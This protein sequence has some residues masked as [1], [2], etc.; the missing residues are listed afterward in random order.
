MQM[1][2]Q[3]WVQIVIFEV[4]PSKSQWEKYIN[5]YNCGRAEHQEIRSSLLAAAAFTC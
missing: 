3:I 5:M 2:I 4:L 1:Q